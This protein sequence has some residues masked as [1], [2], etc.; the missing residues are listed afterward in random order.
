MKK[1]CARMDEPV[2]DGG[3]TSDCQTIAP[4]CYRKWVAQLAKPGHETTQYWPLAVGRSALEQSDHGVEYQC[5]TT[6]R[7]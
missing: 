1:Y 4:F 3:R 6:V 5:S 2:N 7:Q